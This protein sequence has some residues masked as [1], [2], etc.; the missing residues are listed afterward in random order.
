M[1]VSPNFLAS[2]NASRAASSISSPD[3]SGICRYTA[4]I[5]SSLRMPVG[6]PVLGSFTIVPPGGSGESFVM[7][8]IFSTYEFANAMCPSYR[9]T[10]TGVFG[11]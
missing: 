5:A 4:D 8:A 9:F 10:N 3:A 1:L 11:V 2:A 7:P 6:S